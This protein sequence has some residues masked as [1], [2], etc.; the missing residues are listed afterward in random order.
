MEVWLER[1][2]LDGHQAVNG[3]ILNIRYH[4]YQTDKEAE[5]DTHKKEPCKDIQTNARELEHKG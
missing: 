5:K 3:Q 1:A 4:I 2:H